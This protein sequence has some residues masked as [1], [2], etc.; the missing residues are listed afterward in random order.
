MAVVDIDKD[1]LDDIV[2]LDNGTTFRI[3]FQQVGGSFSSYVFPGTFSSR[4]WGV[5]VADVDQNG[6][7]DIAVGGTGSSTEIWFADGPFN[8]VSF[9]SF[10]LSDVSFLQGANFVD[11]NNDGQVDFFACDDVD[12]SK[13]YLGTGGQSMTYDLSLLPAYSTVPSDNSGNYASIWT[14]YDDDGDGDMYLSKCRLGVGD[15]G[16]GRRRNQLFRNEG[17]GSFTDVA[18]AAGLLPLAQSWSADFAD[19]DND[20]DMDF[21]VVNHD[22][23]GALYRNDGNNVFTDVTAATGMAGSLPISSNGI[24]CNFEDFNNDGW[25]DLLLRNAVQ[26][27]YGF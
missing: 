8:P 4:T 21:F 5:T 9:S 18:E 19:I 10:A 13:P 17:N 14:D 11:I 20:G 22:K 16:D 2:R 15:P 24:Q 12:I 7:R 26:I 23:S 1:G 6:M 3:E 27:T 25:I